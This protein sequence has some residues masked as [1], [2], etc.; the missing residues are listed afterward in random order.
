MTAMADLTPTP[1]NPGL[2]ISKPSRSATARADFACHCGET[3]H[4]SGDDNVRSMSDYYAAHKNTH[5]GRK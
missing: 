2:R 3:G 1:D 4:T 5:G